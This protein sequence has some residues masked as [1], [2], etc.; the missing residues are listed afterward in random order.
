MGRAGIL[1]VGAA[2]WDIIARAACSLRGGDDV[3][4]RINR[5]PG[6]VALNV[7]LGLATWDC[8]VS[9]CAAV[10]SDDAA[11]SLIQLSESAG[12]D[13]EHVLRIEA[14]TTDCYV[15]IEH[16]V[17]ELFAAVADV[18]LLDLHADKIADQVAAKIPE[19]ET[20]F[21]DANL[22]K[23]AIARLVDLARGAGVEIVANPVSPAKAPALKVLLSGHH[24]PTL[25]TNLDEANILLHDAVTTSSEAAKAL[26]YHG[27]RTALVTDGPRQAT[28]ATDMGVFTAM[29]PR[30]PKEASVTGAGDA[31]IAAF[32]ASPDRFSDPQVALNVALD[33][34][35]KHMMGT[36]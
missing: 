11:H 35:A 18:G 34:S 15:A 17:G 8:T 33:A 25:I 29:P 31:L 32:L 2:H 6:G 14:S 26:L 27:A 21:V 22:G 20:L 28:L 24:Q 9:L 3:P 13:C 23:T 12:V 4:G 7:A 36:E 5:R 30:L 16:K 1:C 19:V 10:G